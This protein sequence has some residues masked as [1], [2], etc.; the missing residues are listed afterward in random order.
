MKIKNLNINQIVILHLTIIFS[1]LNLFD[2]I[3]TYVVMGLGGEEGNFLMRVLISQSWGLFF[4]VKIIFSF[5][6]PFACY[7]IL[8]EFPSLYKFLKSWIIFLDILF[9]IIVMWNILGFFV[10][11]GFIDI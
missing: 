7:L 3:I 10:L 5:L 2:A 4:G 9:F 8:C 6:V 11:N 1:L